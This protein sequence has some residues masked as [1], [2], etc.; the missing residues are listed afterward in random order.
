MNSGRIANPTL[1]GN[2]GDYAHFGEVLVDE[3]LSRQ[4]FPGKNVLFL[5][6]YLIA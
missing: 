6:A 3:R 2:S 5:K 4:H 1:D